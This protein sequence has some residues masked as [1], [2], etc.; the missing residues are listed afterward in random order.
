MRFFKLSVHESAKESRLILPLL[1]LGALPAFGQA[2][3]I[4]TPGVG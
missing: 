3:E 2:Q 1:L 4:H